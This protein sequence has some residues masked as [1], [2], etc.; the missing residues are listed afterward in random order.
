MR[1][2][3]HMFF[4]GDHRVAVCVLR[5]YMGRQRRKA[6]LPEVC[7]CEGKTRDCK[8]KMGDHANTH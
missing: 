2:C 6:R 7:D 5:P 8:R 4:V 3:E 1:K